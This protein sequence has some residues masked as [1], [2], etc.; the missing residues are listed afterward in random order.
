MDSDD[1]KRRH[2]GMDMARNMCWWWERADGQQMLLFTIRQPLLGRSWQLLLCLP[3]RS[4]TASE[5]ILV[6]EDEQGEIIGKWGTC[7]DN[8]S[9]SLV[10]KFVKKLRR[11][12]ATGQSTGNCA[13]RPSAYG[14]ACEVSVLGSLLGR[15]AF[16]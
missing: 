14:A 15:T 1:H 6:A 2:S 13:R 4:R 3:V 5:G 16:E 9:P 8:N 7:Y 11:G 10:K 12:G